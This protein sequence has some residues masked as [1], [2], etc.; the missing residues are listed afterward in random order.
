MGESTGSVNPAAFG[1]HTVAFYDRIYA[2]KDYDAEVAY[3]LASVADGGRVP[4]SVF[5]VACG[6]G[7]H[8][9]AFARRGL[10]VGG[11][12]LIP[13]MVEAANDR[14]GTN[15][16]L[17]NGGPYLGR[18]VG[19]GDLRGFSVDGRYDLVTCLFSSIGYAGT[20]EQLDRSIAA[21]AGHLNPGGALVI[22]P[23]YP[24]EVWLDGR[25]GHDLME[26]DDLTIVRLARS[27]RR[28]DLAIIDFL[29]AAAT[30][31]E[32]TTWEE[33][34]ELLLAPPETYVAAMER[35]G[36]ATRFDPEG[37]PFRGGGRG[38]VIG[39]HA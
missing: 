27:S 12:D 7:A 35:C 33:R 18:P 24:P 10:A 11:L 9:A 21:M 6:T 13:G 15:G 39:L 31:T 4:D 20:V 2:D 38:L 17:G 16:R 3:V 30:P 36:L 19:L 1:E 26:L 14:L 28:G 32:F 23:F 5:D 37:F 34:H 29:H 8:L 25:V 22:E